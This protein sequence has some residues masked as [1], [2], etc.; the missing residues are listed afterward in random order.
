LVTID[1]VTPAERRDVFAM[2]YDADAINEWLVVLSPLV[3]AP[4][5]AERLR[6]GGQLFSDIDREGVLL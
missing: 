4:S 6:R 2:A 1:D 3:Y 5:E